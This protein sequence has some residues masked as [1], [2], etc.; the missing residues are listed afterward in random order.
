LL[1]ASNTPDSGQAYVHVQRNVQSIVVPL[2]LFVQR[3][4]DHATTNAM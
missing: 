1:Y 2:G 4:N 3:H